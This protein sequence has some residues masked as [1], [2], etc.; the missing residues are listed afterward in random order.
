M[1]LRKKE[2]FPPE[3]AL[4]LDR[5]LGVFR[6]SVR[7]RFLTFFSFHA[8]PYLMLVTVGN[9]WFWTGMKP[10]NTERL[11]SGPEPKYVYCKQG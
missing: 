9:T 10:E 6:D 2:N 3:T 8:P 1:V 5:R 11:H 7:S 4:M